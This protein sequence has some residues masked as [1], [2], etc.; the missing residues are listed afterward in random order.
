MRAVVGRAP[1]SPRAYVPDSETVI[2]PRHYSRGYP[3]QN[4][5]GSVNAVIEIPTGTTGKFEVDEET[6]WLRWQHAREGGSAT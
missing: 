2:G 4:D 6:G 1:V 3:A 5:D